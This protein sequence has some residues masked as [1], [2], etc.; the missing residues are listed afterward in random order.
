MFSFAKQKLFSFG[1]IF[2][3]KD[4]GYKNGCIR[5]GWNNSG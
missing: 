1:V 5:Y 3:I 2:K 4:N